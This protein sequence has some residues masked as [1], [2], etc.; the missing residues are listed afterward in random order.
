VTAYQAREE[1]HRAL[2]HQLST[3]LR[4]LGLDCTLLADDV[5]CGNPVRPGDM[6]RL[7]KR[8]ETIWEAIA[9]ERAGRP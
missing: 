7:E 4:R 1:E 6:R 2:V 5:Q 9:L 8:I 3:R